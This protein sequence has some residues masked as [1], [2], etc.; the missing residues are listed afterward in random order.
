MP[1][2]CGS[3]DGIA[4]GGGVCR[5]G[6]QGAALLWANLAAATR[7][8]RSGAEPQRQR[9]QRQLASTSSVNGSLGGSLRSASPSIEGNFVTLTGLKPIK[10]PKPAKKKGSSA[11][12]PNHMS[13][14]G[15]AAAEDDDD[16]DDD[17]DAFKG[18]PGMGR[19]KVPG[20]RE[21]RR[22][23]VRERRACRR[24]PRRRRG[25]LRDRRPRAGSSRRT[26]PP[27]RGC[28]RLSPLKIVRKLQTK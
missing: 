10:T 22:V 13:E 23:G 28:C 11:L 18:F 27:P 7:P 14:N 16:D 19:V 17:D 9:Q 15:A 25:A 12:G 21:E 6:A 26:W 2:A 1:E 3:T 5:A 8:P 4:Q 20:N 24:R